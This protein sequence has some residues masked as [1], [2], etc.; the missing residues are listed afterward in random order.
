M[1][2]HCNVSYSEAWDMPV[3][4]RRWWFDRVKKEREEENKS[5]GAPPRGMR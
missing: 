2:Y 4:V 5:G 1:T 3:P